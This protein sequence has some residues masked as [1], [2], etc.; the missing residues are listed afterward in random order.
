MNKKRVL[1]VEDDINISK[2]VKLYL[3][4][5]GFIVSCFENGI[6]ACES[7]SKNKYDIALLDLMLPGLDGYEICRK[8]RETSYTPIIMITAKGS[9]EEKIKGLKIGA[10]DYIA[11]PFEIH[12][13][14]ARVHAMLRRRELDYEEVNSKGLNRLEYDNLIF[15]ID[16]FEIYLNGEMINVPRREAQLLQH[17]MKYPNQVFT[18]DDLIEGIWGLDFD[19]EDRVIDVYIKRLRKRLKTKNKQSWSIKTVWGIGYKLEVVK[20]V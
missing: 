19:G 3:E 5:E 15:D 16:S 12:E 10:D 17:L 8:I 6:E 14:I 13:L 1:L 9:L 11:K 4:N 7:F 18:R 2:I 20:N